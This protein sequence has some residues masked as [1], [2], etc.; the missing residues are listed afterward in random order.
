V[1]KVFSVRLGDD[2]G[3]R[4]V[5]IAEARGVKAPTVLKAAVESYVDDFG[6][7]APD[8]PAETP[9]PSPR[10]E[11]AARVLAAVQ[12]G[13]PEDDARARIRAIEAKAARFAA[14]EKAERERKYR[15]R[16]W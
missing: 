11:Q 5:E 16:G 3:A 2:L 6:R 9:E 10:R 13:P 4:V 7:G 15:E 1:S 12:A 8:V 14:E